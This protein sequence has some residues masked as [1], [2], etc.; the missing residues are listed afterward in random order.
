[1]SRCRRDDQLDREPAYRLLATDGIRYAGEVLIATN[2]LIELQGQ[3]DPTSENL[4]LLSDMAKFQ[5]NFAAM[6]SAPPPVSRSTV[7]S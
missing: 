7:A 2:T 6:L 4:A 3:Q 1:M 5:G